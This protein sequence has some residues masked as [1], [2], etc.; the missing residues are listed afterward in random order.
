MSD[1]RRSQNDLLTLTKGLVKC[2]YGRYLLQRQRSVSKQVTKLR[3]VTPC[4][5]YHRTVK[6][7]VKRVMITKTSR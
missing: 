5:F 1:R 3:K 7:N 2:E 6:Y 4:P